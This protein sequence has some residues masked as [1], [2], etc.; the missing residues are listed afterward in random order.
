MP[1]R[2]QKQE[3]PLKSD[4]NGNSIPQIIFFYIIN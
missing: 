4:I 2:G 1:E 3:L